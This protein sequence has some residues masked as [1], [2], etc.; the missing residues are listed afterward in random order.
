MLS[1]A[2]AVVAFVWANIYMLGQA[3][4]GHF[5]WVCGDCG[6]MLYHAP[7]KRITY[8]RVPATY[9]AHPHGWRLE[10]RPPEWSAWKPWQ[11]LVHI[12]ADSAVLEQPQPTVL[13]RTAPVEGRSDA[14][15]VEALSRDPGYERA[16]EIVDWGRGQTSRPE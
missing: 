6:T 12:S 16:S 14:S 8:L 15:G 7:L 13:F 5:D 2:G 4:G 9:R 3:A 1:M 10:H 11:W